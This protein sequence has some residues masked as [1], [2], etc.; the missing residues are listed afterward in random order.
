[1]MDFLLAGQGIG[2]EVSYLPASQSEAKNVTIRMWF[3]GT[4]H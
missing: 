2:V 3:K 4:P 1:M